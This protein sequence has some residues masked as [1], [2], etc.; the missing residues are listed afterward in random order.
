M[1]NKFSNTV[2]QYL[3][4]MSILFFRF[5]LKYPLFLAILITVGV[6]TF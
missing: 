1:L 4:R 2:C 5:G 3:S 6:E